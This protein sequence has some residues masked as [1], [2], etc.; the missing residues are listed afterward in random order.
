M[1][2][3]LL[4]GLASL[5]LLSSCG[6][7]SFGKG[8]DSNDD[9][10]KIY[11]NSDTDFNVVKSNR[12]FT[13]SDNGSDPTLTN[14][15]FPNHNAEIYSG[16]DFIFEETSKYTGFT[17]K[18]EETN[19][20]FLIEGDKNGRVSQ[21]D[22]QLKTYLSSAR[23][24]IDTDYQVALNQYEKMKSF[25]GKEGT[26]EV[27]GTSY[28]NVSLSLAD[29]KTTLGYTLKYTYERNGGTRTEEHYITLDDAGENKWG[30][31]FY[32][33]RITDL[34]GGTESYYVTEYQFTC[35]NDTS[36]SNR[37]LAAKNNL[38]NYSFM[39]EDLT[40]DDV[41][42]DDGTPLTKK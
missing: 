18:Y 6:I 2:K 22:T 12:V 32:S 5:M 21:D 1:K 14:A 23:S 10:V 7:N 11:K 31:T 40:N 8:I 33:K 9:F 24:I 39:A 3:N 42:L 13:K 17:I 27:D 4:L 29:A 25:T 19:T 26:A 30:I 35:V 28:S 20:Y 36:L 38:S 16:D 41:S 37:V 34:I 15:L